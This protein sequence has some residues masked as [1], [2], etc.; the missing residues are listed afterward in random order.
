MLN[1]LDLMG[2]DESPCE[3]GEQNLGYLL[4]H[5]M[6]KAVSHLSSIPISFWVPSSC[7]DTN[8][9]S[10]HGHYHYVN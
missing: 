9:E 4:E 6:L 2:G 5:Q 10:I 8:M 1:P 3:Y 7:L